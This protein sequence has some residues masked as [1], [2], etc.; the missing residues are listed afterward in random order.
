VTLKTEERLDAIGLE[1]MS[2]KNLEQMIT[3]MDL[4]PEER[5]KLTIE[6]L[7][8]KMDSDLVIGLE[9]VRRGPRGPEP[10]HAF[11]VRFTYTDAATAASVAETVGKMFVEQNAKDRGALAR[12][13]SQFLE[14][15]LIGT[16]KKLEEYEQRL[17][18]FRQR[19]GNELPSQAQA[20]LQAIQST[21]L[22]VQALVEQIARDRDRK[23]MLERLYREALNEPAPAVTT[24]VAQPGGGNTTVVAISA[25]QQLD[26][27]RATLAS[28]ELRYKPDHPDVIRAKQLIADLEPKAAAEVAAAQ[29]AAATT[30]SQTLGALPLDPARRENSRQMLAEIESLDRQSAFKESEER[31]LRAEIAQYQRRIEAVPGVESE[32]VKLSRDYDTQQTAYKD[33]LNKVENA[34][35]AVDLEDEQIGEQFRVVEAAGVTPLPS[36]RPAVNAGGLVVGL[37]LGLAIAV[38][39][40]L[41]DASFRSE[42]DVL[43]SLSLPVLASVPQVFTTSEVSGQRR[44]TIVLASLGALSIVVMGYVTWTMQLWN[45]LV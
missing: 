39:L 37:I 5:N 24:P 28:L 7:I 38:L 42:G 41:R 11:H 32:W 15:Q 1:V 14:E 2:R 34:R 26:N 22:Q 6:E 4:Y 43:E 31:R 9:P 36:I 13:T 40:E 27:A 12:A 23:Q 29:A 33:L 19:H 17:E 3:Q 45:S 8:A 35:L 30:S 44:R 25:R 10:A 21:Q 16:R 18:V 20:N